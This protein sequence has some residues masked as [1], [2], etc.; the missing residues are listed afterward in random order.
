[1]RR[2]YKVSRSAEAVLNYIVKYKAE[3]N[4]RS[5]SV[6]EIMKGCDFRS[7]C[8]AHY[9]LGRL[10]SAGLIERD[11]KKSRSIRVIRE[12]CSCSFSKEANA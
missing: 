3:N 10:Q 2:D 4:G 9:H 11:A 1:M 8:V 7:T 5:P 6:R 12:T